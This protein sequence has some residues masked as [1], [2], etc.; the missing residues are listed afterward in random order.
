METILFGAGCFWHV[1]KIFFNTKGVMTTAVGYAGGQTNNPTYNQVCSGLTGH[2]EVV[3]VEFNENEI[4]VKEL[5]NIFWE[6]HDPTQINRQGPD[7]GSQYR[8]CIFSSNQNHLNIIRDIIINIENTKRYRLPIAT[9]LYE[10]EKFWLAEE[11]HQKY[12][13][14]NH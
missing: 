4:S 11:Y 7:I 1:E 2:A 3:K 14:K 9:I 13:I 5:L 6:I 10:E 12:L 8:S